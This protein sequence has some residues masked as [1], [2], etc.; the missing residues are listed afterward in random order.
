MTNAEPLTLDV[1]EELRSGGE[2]L[3]R[4]LAA[5]RQLAPG[6]SLR[7]LATFEPLPLYAVL[8]RKGFGHNAIHHG[9]G[10][11]EVLFTPGEA[12]SI[13][14]ARS[15]K[16]APANRAANG[17][18]G[19]AREGSETWPD[20]ATRLD[21][22]GLQPPEPLVRILDALEHLPNGGVLEAINERDP[23]FLYPELEARGAAIRVDKR[24][25]G[26]YLLIRR[27]AG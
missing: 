9:E 24:A 6:Q 16:T 10:D 13:D 18:A 12:G 8:G 14:S 1:R 20:P 22:R 4:I 5:V 17:R 23:M 15:A 26:V 21:N 2:P 11:W 7:L 19:E 3:P 27:A 25:D